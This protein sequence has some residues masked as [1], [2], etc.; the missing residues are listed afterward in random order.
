MSVGRDAQPPICRAGAG[1]GALCL[2]AASGA[3]VEPFRFL[4]AAA[5]AG[6]KGGNFLP[7]PQGFLG[8][9]TAWTY[10][11]LLL[12]VP[13]LF[14]TGGCYDPQI[15]LRNGSASAVPGLTRPPASG[16]EMGARR[17][18]ALARLSREFGSIRRLLRFAFKTF[19]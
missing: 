14:H 7:I 2:H 6:A 8:Q 5:A 11:D 15:E 10:L 3:K 12:R 18:G 13:N 19:P 9:I 1:A 4:P 17:R 16:E